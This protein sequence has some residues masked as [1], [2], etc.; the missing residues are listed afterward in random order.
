MNQYL[1]NQILKNFAPRQSDISGNINNPNQ[2]EVNQHK[3]IHSQQALYEQGLQQ[4]KLQQ[5]MMQQYQYKNPFQN[6]NYT[7]PNTALVE[8]TIYAHPDKNYN[9]YK[10][11]NVGR[12]SNVG[13]GTTPPKSILT[14]PK[15]NRPKSPG[16]KVHFADQ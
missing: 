5:Q 15:L 8:G 12:N 9:P 6:H 13:I 11:S 14:P 7:K 1:N 16:K 2:K 10:K 4:Q 3:N